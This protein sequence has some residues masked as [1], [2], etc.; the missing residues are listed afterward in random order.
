MTKEEYRQKF[1]EEDAVGWLAIDHEFEKLYPGQEP[2]HYGTVLKYMLGGKEPLDG[3]S[4]YESDRQTGHFH[5]VSY[6]FSQ[7]YYDEES[8]EEDFSK[9]G[10][11]LTFRVKKIPDEKAS[12]QTWALNMMQNLAKYVFTNNKWFEEYHTIDSRA[13]IR[14]DYDTGVTA[15]VFVLDPELGTIN[16]PNGVVQFLQIVGLTAKEYEELKLTRSTGSTAEF[17][18]KLKVGNP[19]LITDLDKK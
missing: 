11:E 1:T 16:T 10:F 2:K 3:L 7:L 4:I 14:I 19:L 9:W 13:P 6:G 15:V 17:I 5:I 8:V 18:S 12:D